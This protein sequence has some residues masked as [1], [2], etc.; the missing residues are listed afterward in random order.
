MKKL[1][2]REFQAAK[3]GMGRRGG[4]AL[5]EKLLGLEFGVE[6]LLLSIPLEKNGKSERLHRSRGEEILVLDNV[7][8]F[9]SRRRTPS[10]FFDLK[11][12]FSGR[13][14]SHLCLRL[15]MQKKECFFALTR[16]IVLSG[17]FRTIRDVAVRFP[18][19]IASDPLSRL[20]PQ[21]PQHALLMTTAED[22]NSLP[23]GGTI[24]DATNAR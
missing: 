8:D 16:S 7:K 2:S 3:M 13:F 17:P 18:D 11:A 5:S 20:D 1:V 9:A 4:K 21:F 24:R 22:R 10:S 12:S 15:R 6:C 19:R 23:D 14:L